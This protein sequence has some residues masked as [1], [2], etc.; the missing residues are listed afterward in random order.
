MVSDLNLVRKSSGAIASEI[1]IKGSKKLK[2]FKKCENSFKLSG[3]CYTSPPR[4]NQVGDLP[5][6]LN[7]GLGQLASGLVWRLCVILHENFL[8]RLCGNRAFQ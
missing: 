5:R 8:V 1:F 2:I 3:F 4:G 7:M 6:A